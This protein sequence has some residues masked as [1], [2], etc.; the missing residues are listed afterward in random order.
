M[1][2]DVKDS[3][4]VFEPKTIATSYTIN[5]ESTF[6]YLFA[7]DLV[8]NE[9]VWLNLS[10]DSEVHVAGTTPFDFLLDYFN[11]TDVINV[12]DLFEMLATKV[13]KKPE[14]ADVVVT[15]KDVEVKEGAEVI[16][17]Y[18]FERILA[19]MNKK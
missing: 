7:L 13:V 3:G 17:S 6:A 8:K 10:R 4:E 9:I 2:R 15:D 11:M 14:L 5:A 19:Y 18:D 12:Y 1:L 16:R